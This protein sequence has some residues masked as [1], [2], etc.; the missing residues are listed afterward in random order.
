MP[1]LKP[2]AGRKSGLKDEGF[3]IF[4]AQR[5]YVRVSAPSRTCI[6][7]SCCSRDGS[8]DISHVFISK[9][10]D[11]GKLAQIS[12]LGGWRGDLVLEPSA[13]SALSYFAS[14]TFCIK[15]RT[16]SAS[17]KLPSHFTQQKARRVQSFQDVEDYQLGIQTAR[18][19]SLSVWD[20]R[21]LRNPILRADESE[22]LEPQLHVVKRRD[23][24]RRCWE[25]MLLISFGPRIYLMLSVE[26]VQSLPTAEEPFMTPTPSQPAVFHRLRNFKP[27]AHNQTNAAPIAKQSCPG[28]N[29]LGSIA[30]QPHRK[31]RSQSIPVHQV[32]DAGHKSH[33]V[34]V[35]ELSDVLPH[36]VTGGIT[37]GKGRQRTV[38]AIQMSA[39]LSL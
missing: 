31:A 33:R 12:H 37:Q 28:A 10:R 23:Q 4:Q 21:P 14:D 29:V 22:T 36:H 16:Y 30:T 13:L 32:H 3:I 26:M 2:P 35:L 39:R 1:S 11:E 34:G 9:R 24:P 25:W 17:K 38:Y 5:N 6:W 19:T 27:K 20:E 15:V 7:R 18:D 8:R